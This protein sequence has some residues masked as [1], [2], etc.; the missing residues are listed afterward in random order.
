MLGCS[1]RYSLWQSFF[2][3]HGLRPWVDVFHPLVFVCAPAN[4]TI[5]MVIVWSVQWSYCSWREAYNH[6]YQIFSKI[7]K[8]Q[9]LVSEL[10][11]ILF[12]LHSRAWAWLWNAILMPQ[13]RF[14]RPWSCLSTCDWCLEAKSISYKKC[15]Y[16]CNSVDM[17][18]DFFCGKLDSCVGVKEEH[19]FLKPFMIREPIIVPSSMIASVQC[20]ILA[21]SVLIL[22]TFVCTSC[23]ADIGMRTTCICKSWVTK[24]PTVWLGSRIRAR[25]CTWQEMT[26]APTYL[27]GSWDHIIQ[28]I[29]RK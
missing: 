19:I 17:Y 9:T 1:P 29:F 8:N 2:L 20:L 25:V 13:S 3:S 21:I 16:Q 28:H 6:I 12:V 4:P 27:T 24:G 5:K 7:T 15:N 11:L 26:L 22:S 10:V 23:T 18:K 14:R